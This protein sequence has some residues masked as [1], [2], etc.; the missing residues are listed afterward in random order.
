LVLLRT[1]LLLGLL[2]NIPRVHRL[3]HVGFLHRY[4]YQSIGRPPMTAIVAPDRECGVQSIIFAG[5]GVS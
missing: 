4:I 3:C 2:L 5:V 1:G